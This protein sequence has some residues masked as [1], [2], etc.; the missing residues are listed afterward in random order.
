MND[1]YN[2][3]SERLWEKLEA[4]RTD[5]VL[6][7][8]DFKQPFP[9]DQIQP[10]DL[11]MQLVKEVQDECKYEMSEFQCSWAVNQFIR[12]GLDTM[13]QYNEKNNTNLKPKT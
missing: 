2:K 8:V 5:F 13:H 10:Q 12:G 3:T 6:N 4:R 7:S 11:F 1:L 9:A